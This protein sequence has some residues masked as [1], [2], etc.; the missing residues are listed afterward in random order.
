V[1]P[2]GPDR[3]ILLAKVRQAETALHLEDLLKS[4]HAD[5]LKSDTTQGWLRGELAR[6]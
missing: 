1:L 4:S 5:P 6:G 3:D 2:P